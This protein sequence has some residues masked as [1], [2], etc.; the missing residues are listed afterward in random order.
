MIAILHGHY[1]IHALA[2]KRNV[3]CTRTIY[4]APAV[5]SQFSTLTCGL[6]KS[7]ASL[8]D[9]ILF[10]ANHIE[11]TLFISICTSCE[12]NTHKYLR[13]RSERKYLYHLTD[14]YTRCRHMFIRGRLRY[15]QLPSVSNSVGPQF[16]VPFKAHNWV[17]WWVVHAC[18]A[19]KTVS[20]LCPLLMSVQIRLWGRSED[21]WLMRLW[22]WGED[23]WLMW[24]LDRYEGDSRLVGTPGPG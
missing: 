22:G 8:A 12:L 19:E 3:V 10:H 7:T 13:K 14:N 2:S 4:F 11:V 1:I 16:M 9:A 23:H 24:L 21:G 6:V 15:H 5:T 20:C 18:L 17:Q